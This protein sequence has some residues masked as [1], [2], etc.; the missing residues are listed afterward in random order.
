[1]ASSIV[2]AGTNPPDVAFG[3]LMDLAL[4]RTDLGSTEIC[5]ACSTVNRGPA[6]F[7]KA[8]SHKLPAFYAARTPFEATMKSSPQRPTPLTRNWTWDLGAFW[9]VITVLA[10]VTA[11]VPVV[12]PAAG[13]LP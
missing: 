10:G 13:Y 1:V 4:A 2:V 7:C 3:S 5:E 12:Y 8:C 6:R 9:L 11:G